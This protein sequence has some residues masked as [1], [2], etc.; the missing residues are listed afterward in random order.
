VASRQGALS[1]AG[2]DPHADAHRLDARRRVSSAGAG[3]SGGI[4][5]ALGI[6]NYRLF[7]LGQI[8]SVSGTFM[9]TTAQQWLVLQLSPDPLAL[10]IV[11]AFQFGPLLVLAPFGGIAADRWQR[12]K[13]LMTTQ[14]CAALLA[15]TLWILTWTSL[16]QLWHVFALAFLLGLVNAVDMPTRQAFVSEMVGPERL[17]NAVSLN[18][19]QFNVAR[20]LGPGLAGALI[21]LVGEPLLFLGNALSFLAVIAG[22]AMMRPSELFPVPR[23]H[24]LRGL[25]QVRALGEGIGFIRRTPTL[26]ITLLLVGVTGTFGFNFNVL[27][28][29][30][31]KRMLHA[32]PQ[33]FGLVSSALGAG[34]LVG[35]LFLARRRRPPTNRL[36]VGGVI[37]FGLLESAMALTNSGLA[38]GA[39]DWIG[40]PELQANLALINF[41]VVAMALIAL[42]GLFMS[43]FSASANTRTQLT[44]PPELRG[45]VMSI[46]M[47]LFAGTTPIGNLLI[48]VV[49]GGPGGVSLAWVAAG[50]PC[51]LAGIAGAVL[52]RRVPAA[53]LAAA[54]TTR[55]LPR[56][57]IAAIGT[58]SVGA[59]SDTM[60]GK[61]S[62][63]EGAQV[64]ADA[65]DD[66]ALDD[67]LDV[68]AARHD[69][70]G[71]RES[72]YEPT[73]DVPEL[74]D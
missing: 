29:L 57:E 65:L 41:T 44:S 33:V 38:R 51:V 19:A 23:N 35:A 69:D 64:V 63:A 11:G 16:V 73:R 22:L 58:A 43:T 61:V 74:V 3:A 7:W 28:P 52:Y 49:A 6:R 68:P 32:G 13:V 37:A 40:S 36:L 54:A 24:N 26:W 14:T 50:A 67:A 55:T 72:D 60:S 8:V 56:G 15:F 1:E 18:S 46:Y 20:I 4:F 45:R 17:L 10:G 25:Q 66:G 39:A 70:P 2:P 71:A 42:V 30:E 47:M 5:S 53:Q 12:R 21:A 31:A 9:Q 62:E 27:L 59:L 48:S 34:A